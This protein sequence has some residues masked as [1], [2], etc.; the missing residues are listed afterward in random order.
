VSNA[1]EL[2]KDEGTEAIISKLVIGGDLSGLTPVQKVAYYNRFCESLGLNPLTKPFDILRLNGKEIL[3]A[4]KDAT[5]QLRKINGVSVT[6]L[7]QTIQQ[8]III[9]TATGNDKTG[10]TDAATGAVN[11]AG[12]KGDAL[13]NAIMKAET[14]AKR[15]LTLSI[16]GLG[17][18]DETEIE[19]IPGAVVQTTTS[20][21][22][23]PAPEPLTPK[24]NGAA[25]K[26]TPIVTPA[27]DERVML[28]KE[29]GRLATILG[30]DSITA[31][32]GQVA[33]LREDAK[34][35]T[36]IHAEHVNKLREFRI[37]LE[38]NVADKG[39]L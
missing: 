37:S 13:A 28:E 32:R 5:E 34:A 26:S 20:R 31:A 19:T 22:A 18:L 27:F 33:K 1:I 36:L 30:A 10:R 39:I 11:I 35:G 7:N 15:R 3:Y 14:K 2:V 16:C 9:V 23:L 6:S 25:P 24:V 21:E 38:S 12:L 8:D 29:I 4:K 17:V